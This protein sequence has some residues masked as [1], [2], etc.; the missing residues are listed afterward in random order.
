MNKLRCAILDD[1]QQIALSSADWSMIADNVNV[2]AFQQHFVNEDDVVNAIKDYE[3]VIIMRERTPFPASLLGR[4]SKLKLLITTGM[5]NAAIDLV[6][7]KA[8]GIKVCGTA[9]LSTPPVELTWGLIL[10]L[11]RISL[12]KI[13][14]CAAMA[15]GK[16]L[17]VLT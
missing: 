7:A 17:S 5:R 14:L 16:A 8:K 13:P 9:S 1:Y 12:K 2:Q 4:L 15:L 3:I 11:A 10:G 6:A